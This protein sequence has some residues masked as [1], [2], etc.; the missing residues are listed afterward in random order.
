MSRTPRRHQPLSKPISRADHVSGISLILSQILV[1]WVF[2]VFS[3][4]LAAFKPMN[5]LE[6]INVFDVN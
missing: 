3:R 2:L 1:F 4:V 6:E 5:S